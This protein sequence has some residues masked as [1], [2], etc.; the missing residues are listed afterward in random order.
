MIVGG[1][2]FLAWLH[3]KRLLRGL[4]AVTVGLLLVQAA[5]LLAAQRGVPP[6]FR[7]GTVDARGA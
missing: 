4:L 1:R 5:A 3:F 6:A 2:S 7:P